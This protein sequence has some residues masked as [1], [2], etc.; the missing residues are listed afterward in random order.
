[1]FAN[2]SD[3]DRMISIWERNYDSRVLESLACSEDP[4]IIYK[5]S[6]LFM[7][8]NYLR[9]IRNRDHI[10]VFFN[11]IAKHVKNDNVLSFLLENFDKVKPR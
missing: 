5:H 11:I 7:S 4:D 6:K 10:R 3:W 2:V 1:M 8:I 9:K